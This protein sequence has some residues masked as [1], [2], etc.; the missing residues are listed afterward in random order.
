MKKK[1]SGLAAACMLAA[2]FCGTLTAEAVPARTMRNDY[3]DWRRSMLTDEG[4]LQNGIREMYYQTSDYFFS[5]IYPLSS[6]NV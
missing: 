3:A 4:M 6:V 1:L 2:A 5:T